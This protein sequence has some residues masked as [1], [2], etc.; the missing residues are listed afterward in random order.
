[1]AS[2]ALI[3]HLT[4]AWF[5]AT[6]LRPSLKLGHEAVLLFA[7]SAQGP[8]TSGRANSSSAVSQPAG[9]LL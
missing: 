9:G 5:A 2:P 3:A 4:R 1:M 6:G 8:I 7:R